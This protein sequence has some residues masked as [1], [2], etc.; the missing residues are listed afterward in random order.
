MT[1]LLLA[2]RGRG[3]SSLLISRIGAEKAG[4][5]KRK[6][7]DGTVEEEKRGDEDEEDMIIGDFIETSDVV[8]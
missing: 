4:T 5:K 7:N 3:L 8:N 2:K 1:T 6:R